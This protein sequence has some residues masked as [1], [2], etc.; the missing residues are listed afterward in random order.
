M[1]V[2]S[3]FIYIYHTRQEE[4]TT[5]VESVGGRLEVA[6]TCFWDNALT[7]APIS[8]DNA[9]YT[10]RNN[11]GSNN[12]RPV[13]SFGCASSL[14]V[15]RGSIAQ[16]QSARY[17]CDSFDMV[18]CEAATRSI[19]SFTSAASDNGRSFYRAVRYLLPTA[20]LI[21]LFIY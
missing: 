5:L 1:R 11:F 6:S 14:Q 21:F 15:T 10:S 9:I 8:S 17:R 12:S 2:S 18:S 13:S 4:F 7:L 19:A 16:W 20:G 3:H